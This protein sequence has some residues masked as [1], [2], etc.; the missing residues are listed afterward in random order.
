MHNFLRD[1]IS[2]FYSGKID[3][4]KFQFLVLVIFN[5]GDI[6]THTDPLSFCVSLFSPPTPS[7]CWLVHQSFSTVTCF[8]FSPSIM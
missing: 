1:K 4:S 5:L 7:G 2:S 3:A 6:H 8:Y